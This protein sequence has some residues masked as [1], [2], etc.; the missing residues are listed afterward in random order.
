MV[1]QLDLREDDPHSKRI[2]SDT[3]EWHRR[4]EELAKL[5]QLETSKVSRA[6]GMAAGL[7]T[8]M[9][10]DLSFIAKR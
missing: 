6:G 5:R 4:L 7:R 2:M 9:T 10:C 8:R 3:A 1:P